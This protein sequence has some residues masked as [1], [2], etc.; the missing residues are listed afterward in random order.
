MCASIVTFLMPLTTKPL[1]VAQIGASFDPEH[2]RNLVFRSWLPDLKQCL[3][4]RPLPMSPLGVTDVS[5]IGNPFGIHAVWAAGRGGSQYSGVPG[6]GGIDVEDRDV[7]LAATAVR[8]V[9]FQ[10]RCFV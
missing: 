5:L 4:G 8:G 10:E 6:V 2:R 7:T 1:G 9:D 3:G